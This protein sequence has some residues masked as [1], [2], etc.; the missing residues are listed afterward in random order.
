LTTIRTEL[1]F[2]QNQAFGYLTDPNSNFDICY[3]GARGGGKTH[4]GVFWCFYWANWLIDFFDIK[5]PSKTPLVV[6][7][8]GR[9]RGVDF[10][11]TTLEKWKQIIPPHLYT[12][13]EQDKEII[14]RDRVKIY[15]GG[16]DD[17]T[18]IG[19]FKSA[20]FCFI[21]ID[22]AEETERQDV[23]DLE[24]CLR[25][26]YRGKK[27]PYKTLYTANPAECWLKWEFIKGQRKGAIFVP[28]LYNDNPY[29]PT[30]YG[31]RL[32]KSYGYDQALLNAMKYGDWEGLSGVKSLFT[33][34][35]IENCFSNIVKHIYPQDFRVLSCDPAYFGDDKTAIYGANNE[36]IVIKESYGKKEPRETAARLMELR[37]QMGGIVKIC[38]DETNM[39]I[40]SFLDGMLP[41]N[42]KC[43]RIFFGGAAA[44]MPD[45]I[46]D[47]RSEMYWVAQEWIKNR[48]IEIPQDDFEL[49]QDLL[50]I[51]YEKARGKFKVTE[52][53]K[54]KSVLGRSPDKADA[55]V[56]LIYL[57]N[58]LKTTD[59]IKEWNKMY[60]PSK[61]YWVIQ[62]EKELYNP[63]SNIKEEIFY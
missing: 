8:M 19:K 17:E 20:E 23:A 46:A 14:I 35:N 6:G 38:I 16:L 42:H 3:G 57:M 29:L 48:W 12:I 41:D 52:K 11:K 22:Q 9:K 5:K 1:T 53:D 32:D 44:L 54:I 28:A 58:Y 25:M 59:G 62:R 33:T 50:S 39:G 26:V 56:M 55:F 34:S 47:F 27:P 37:Q 18:N 40:G 7:F 21:F 30:E 49:H 10:N 51:T 43:R 36:K 15:Y 61:P 4:V 31:E 13:H 63:Y 60:E 45:L 2:R 24:A